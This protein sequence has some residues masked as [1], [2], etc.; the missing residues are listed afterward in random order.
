MNKSSVI[1]LGI[2]CALVLWMAVGMM[3]QDVEAESLA[4]ENMASENQDD[5]ILVEV[6]EM[7]AREVTSYIVSNGSAAPNREVV[8]RAE[9]TGQ[10]YQILA[11]EGEYVEEGIVIMQLK[12]DDRLIRKEQAS[13]TLQERQRL[14]E[15]MVN[16]N[17]KDF[18]STTEVDSALTQLK[19]AE[20]DL[21]RI[22]LEIEKT[23]IRAPFGGYI[24]E[25]ITELG[26]YVG[27]GNELL[28]L[29][30]NDPLVVN[31]YISQNDVEFLEIGSEVSVQLVNG[32]ERSG[33]IRFI[34]PRANEATRTFRV[35]IAIPNSEGIRTG[36]SVTAKIPKQKV[37]AH[38]FSAGLLTLNDEGD[39]GVKTLTQEGLV[40]FYPITIVSSDADGMWVSGLPS[41]V[42]IITAG[43]GFAPVG[44]SV[45]FVRV[46]QETLVQPAVTPV[47]LSTTTMKYSQL[48]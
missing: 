4:G 17:E 29:V 3:K 13:I 8:L 25:H 46:E 11:N 32:R 47:S 36:S 42:L 26:E 10:I 30:D 37:F 24:E 9:T 18:A 28:R 1:A 45:R 43:H 27:I 23:F 41:R 44:E 14:Y 21:E 15:A 5:R 31:T 40:D 38:Y 34:S 35:E 39:V 12:M 16:L 6:T 7:Q 33:Q 19:L 22:N 20:V 48:K 2:S